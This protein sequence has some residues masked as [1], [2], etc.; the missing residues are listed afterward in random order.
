MRI[1]RSCWHTSQACYSRLSWSSILNRWKTTSSANL[2]RPQPLGAYSLTF[3][4]YFWARLIGLA[5]CQCFKLY[6][7][8]QVHFHTCS[9]ARNLS[10]VFFA[11]YAICTYK[12]A[13]SP[14]SFL[15][16][17]THIQISLLLLLQHSKLFVY[18]TFIPPHHYPLVLPS[19]SIHTIILHTDPA[20]P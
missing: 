4:T 19:F 1:K 9:P 10:T 17:I 12:A 7:L 2:G 18:T 3:H 15:L 6:P 20:Q 11:Q 8:A 5:S 16:L 13:S 14:S